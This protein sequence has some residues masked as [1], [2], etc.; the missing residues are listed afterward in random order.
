MANRRM[1]EAQ[2]PD[3]RPCG[4]LEQLTP[5]LCCKE[6]KEKNYCCLACAAWFSGEA[7]ASGKPEPYRVPSTII[8]NAI[9]LAVDVRNG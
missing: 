2:E 3:R 4:G 1:I 9:A 7:F 6:K 8:S 5:P